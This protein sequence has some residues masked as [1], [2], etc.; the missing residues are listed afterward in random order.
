MPVSD[1]YVVQFLLQET[2]RTNGGVEWDERSRERA[3]FTARV[4]MNVGR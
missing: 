3:G 2:N 1:I 4:A